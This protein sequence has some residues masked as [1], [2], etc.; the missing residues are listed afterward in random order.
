MNTI[1]ASKCERK[2]PSFFDLKKTVDKSQNTIEGKI[3]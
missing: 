3:M 2:I 1:K